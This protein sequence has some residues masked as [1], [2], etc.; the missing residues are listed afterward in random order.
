M[1]FFLL[2]SCI[3]I[4]PE[5]F[6][7]TG[8]NED[9]DWW[10]LGITFYECVYGTVRIYFIATIFSQHLI[11]H[12]QQQ[13]PW[14]HCTNIDEL[15]KQILHRRISFPFKQSISI[16]C[17]SAIKCVRKKQDNFSFLIHFLYIYCFNNIHAIT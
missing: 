2:Y 17:V 5:Y 3:Y 8:Y 10:S 9:V 13:R 11:F 4:A 16:E 14:L 6:K 12:K 15:S 1:F 7:C